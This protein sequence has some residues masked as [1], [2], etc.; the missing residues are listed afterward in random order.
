L[1]RW[2]SRRRFRAHDIPHQV[3]AS[4]HCCNHSNSDFAAC[5]SIAKIAHSQ[6]GSAL[7]FIRVIGG[8][9]VVGLLHAM[10]LFLILGIGCDDAFIFFVICF[11]FV[12]FFSTWR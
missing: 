10:V 12:L 8:V 1:G 7:F 4:Q 9:K 5:V 2:Q 6:F 3:A 11:A